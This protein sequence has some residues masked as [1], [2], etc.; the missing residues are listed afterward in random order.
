MRPRTRP[1]ARPLPPVLA[2][3]LAAAAALAGGARTAAA[4]AP[5]RLDPSVT[6][7]DGT[8]GLTVQNARRQPVYV[9][10]ERGT[11]ERRLGVVPAMGSATLAFP[12]WMVQEGGT[13][14]L[15]MHPQGSTT[16]FVVES[17][18]L[19]APARYTV[20][21]PATDLAPLPAAEAL[22]VTLPPAALDEAT[23]TIDNPTGREAT[24]FVQQGD[25]DV[26]LGT[27][28]AGGRVTLRVPP[29]L[30]DGSALELFLEPQ[31]ATTQTV[32]L[33]LGRGEH[34]AVRMTAP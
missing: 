26:R 15:L 31:G 2:A 32:R 11:F 4:Q 17:L 24:A 16:D 28:P 34:V 20:D 6:T 5:H 18:S 7:G 14:R 22:E 8:P 29:V 33:R 21:V 9:Y 30:A 23:L 3:L 25:R 13:M 10:L 19:A 1:L 27:V 12:A